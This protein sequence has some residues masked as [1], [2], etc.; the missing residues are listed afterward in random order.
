MVTT[1]NMPAG[2]KE[3]VEENNRKKQPSKKVVLNKCAKCNKALKAFVS[4]GTE[5]FCNDDCM[6]V[7]HAD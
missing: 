4:D 7:Y 5:R 1:K 2:D 3:P 6:N